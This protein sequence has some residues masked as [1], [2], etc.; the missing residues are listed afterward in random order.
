VSSCMAKAVDGTLPQD[1][2]FFLSTEGMLRHIGESKGTEFAVGTELGILHQL[3]KKYPEKK[4]HP[5][6]PRAICAFMKTITLD[7]VIH[8]LETMTPEVRVPEEI[9]NKARRAIHRMLELA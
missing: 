9:A 7:R 8:A 5:V 1:R 2:T 3:K 6:N 4:F